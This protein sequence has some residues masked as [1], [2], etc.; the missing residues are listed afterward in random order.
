[1][2][3]YHNSGSRDGSNPGLFVKNLRCLLFSSFSILLPKLGTS[4]IQQSGF[5]NVYFQFAVNFYI[6]IFPLV[7][8]DAYRENGF[9]FYDMCAERLAASCLSFNESVACLAHSLG[10]VDSL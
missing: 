3:N 8:S 7:R 6:G 1:M 5:V 10:Q 2:F 9:T 4:V